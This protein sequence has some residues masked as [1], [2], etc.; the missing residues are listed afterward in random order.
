MVS[1]ASVSLAGW[2]EVR[3]LV[4]RKDFSELLVEPILGRHFG[5]PIRVI[6]IATIPTA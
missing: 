2:Y 3:L 4:G 1:I 6:S 5:G